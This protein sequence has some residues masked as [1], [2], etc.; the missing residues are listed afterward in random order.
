MKLR[1]SFLFAMAMVGIYAQPCSAANPTVTGSVAIDAPV[2]QSPDRIKDRSPMFHGSLQ[3]PKLIG[4]LTFC[5][6]GDLQLRSGAPFYD[7]NK[8]RL[9]FELPTSSG[10][11]PYLTWERRF[12]INDNRFIAGLRYNFKG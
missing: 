11:C 2:I 10:L 7:E 8:C 9:G 1:I 5:A 12:S 4:P 3:F 6:S